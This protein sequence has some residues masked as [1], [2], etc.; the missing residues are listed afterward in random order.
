MYSAN[1][2]GIRWVIMRTLNVHARFALL[3]CAPCSLDLF[4]GKDPVVQIMALLTSAQLVE[5][6]GKMTNV[7]F[8][9]ASSLV[10]QGFRCFACRVAPW[11][12]LQGAAPVL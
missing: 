11:S 12:P 1:R 4:L 10:L 9:I 7:F 3:R 5:F 8:K 6:V 2:P